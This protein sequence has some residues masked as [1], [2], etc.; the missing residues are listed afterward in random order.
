MPE[1]WTRAFEHPEWWVA[2]WIGLLTAVSAVSLARWTARKRRQRLGAATRPGLPL[3]RDAVLLLALACIGIALLGPR[4]GTRTIWTT[5]SGVDVVLLF[6][7]SRSMDAT[8]VP[9]SRLDHSRRAALDLLARLGTGDRVALAA[10]GDRGVLLTPLTPDRDALVELVGALDTSLI[11]PAGSNLAAGVS[12]A[13]KAFEA[14]SERPRIVVVLSDGESPLERRALGMGAAIAADVRII[15]IAIGTEAGGRIPDHGLPLRDE[16]GHV[17]VSQRHT[18]RLERLATAT[19]GSVFSADAW[20]RID[21]A[22][23]SNAVR[24]D[25][26][27]TPGTPIERRV[28]AV[29]VAPLAALAFGLMLIEA[30]QPL[31]SRIRRKRSPV[32][33]VALATAVVAFAALGVAPPAQNTT[34][35]L[36]E[37]RL[38]QHRGDLRLLFELGLARLE[39]GR[40]EAAQRAFLAAAL[41]TSDPELA[42]LAYYNLGVAALEE[43]SY[44]VARDAFFDALALRPGDRR[45]R[46][47]LEWSLA[48]M[49]AKTHRPEAKSS[50]RLAAEREL[51]APRRR[52][53][54]PEATEAGR[55]TET[56]TSPLTL[57]QERRDRWL[58]RIEDDPTA[59][60]RSA[61][62]A[63]GRVLRRKR[64]AW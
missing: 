27:N 58:A 34:L 8:D 26:G 49:S 32:R 30:L 3:A 4:L 43:G 31:R 10:F 14:G 2:V 54:E 52:E 11:E 20:G 62:R 13:V 63:S 47:N 16:Q 19:D 37:A 61:E 57:D 56:E 12:E 24:R 17:I 64:I 39:R 22:E 44:E 6:D 50:R 35:N 15:A 29:R 42:A 28:R 55:P 18:Q 9:P 53:E 1:T 36:L 33:R 5:T 23:L 60:L 59:A 45:A 51:G 40:Q 46:F 25:A 38:R 48:A 41:S 21:A 7:V